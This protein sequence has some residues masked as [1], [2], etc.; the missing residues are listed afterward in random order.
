LWYKRQGMD[1][2]AVVARP[3]P[4][5][6]SICAIGLKLCRIQLFWSIDSFVVANSPS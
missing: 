2:V 6:L 5:F 4:A 3:S 1:S